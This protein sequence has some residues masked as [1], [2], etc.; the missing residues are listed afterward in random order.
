MNDELVRSGETTAFARALAVA[1]SFET[2]AKKPIFLT[3]ERYVVSAG[4]VVSWVDWLDPSTTYTQAAAG[5]RV[6]EPTPDAN[7]R[8]ALATTFALAGLG[9]YTCSANKTL[10][11]Y[12]HDGTGVTQ[13]NV[14]SCTGAGNFWLNTEAFGAGPGYALGINGGVAPNETHVLRVRN[15]IVASVLSANVVTPLLNTW[16]TQ[17]AE[18]SSARPGTQGE[19]F[20]NGASV[21]AGNELSPPFA[22]DPQT[23]PIQG[24]GTSGKWYATVAIPGILSTAQ[25]AVFQRWI[26]QR[27]G[28]SL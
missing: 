12:M 8:N 7:I 17:R 6:A 5:N 13:F 15:A 16:Q 10:F 11:R 18:Y 14:F 20:V 3:A 2:A 28:L 21:F 9:A 24:N 27:T 22:G 19:L 25:L 26:L 4:N 1:R 23:T